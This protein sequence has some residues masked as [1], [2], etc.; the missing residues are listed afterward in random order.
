MADDDL[1]FEVTAA[2]AP[3]GAVAVKRRIL[4]PDGSIT[5]GDA[6]LIKLWRYKILRCL[7]SPRM[8]RPCCSNGMRGRTSSCC[9]ARRRRGLI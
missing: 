4:N 5:K 6:P 8:S 9:T 7:I 2:K 1:M 3:P